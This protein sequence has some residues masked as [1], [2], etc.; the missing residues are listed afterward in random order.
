MKW[1]PDHESRDGWPEDGKPS[2]GSSPSADAMEKRLGQLQPAALSFDA[3]SVL[4]QAELRPQSAETTRPWL[5]IVLSAAIGAVAGAAL[6]MLLQHPTPAAPNNLPQRQAAHPANDPHRAPST[7]S[8][9]SPLYQPVQPSLAQTP[10]ADASNGPT[11]RM[12]DAVAPLLD[13]R[14][15]VWNTP[16]TPLTPR[17][18]RQ[19]IS[20]PQSAVASHDVRNIDVPVRDVVREQGSRARD[21]TELLREM[22][23]LPPL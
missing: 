18:I 23:A 21:A 2:E 5:T 9:L 1:E 11:P 10:R 4:R 6:T 16:L 7:D 19:P 8:Q 22:G 17:Q 3:A 13:L 14:N 12:D 15:A 20:Q